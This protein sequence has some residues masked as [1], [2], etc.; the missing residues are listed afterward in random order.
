M[1]KKTIIAVLSGVLAA[2]LLCLI[3]GLIVY[4]TAKGNVISLIIGLFVTA[5]GIIIAAAAFLALAVTLLVILLNKN[6]NK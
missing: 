1:S 4:H 5:T 3:V 6:K 2:G